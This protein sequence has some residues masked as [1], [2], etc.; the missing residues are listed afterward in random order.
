MKKGRRRAGIQGL[1]FLAAAMLFAGAAHASENV[2]DIS[3]S[4]EEYPRIDGSLA[5]VPLCEALAVKATGCTQ[6]QAEETMSDFTNTNPCYL[7]LAEGNRDILLAY[8][9]AEETK[10]QLLSYPP[11]D[12]QPIGKDALV[13]IVNKEN[14]VESVTTDQI[15]AI[16]TGDIRNWKE[17]G[18]ADMEIAAFRRPET[19]G[20]Q[21]MLRK[22]LL[23]DAQMIDEQMET[24]PSM[25]GIIDRIRDYDNSANALGYSVYYYA[26][27]MYGQEDLKFLK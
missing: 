16:F 4:Y 17:V 23:G 5:C 12:M 15:R 27:A 22:L 13:F 19:S 24:V 20:S 25:E 14:P 7:Q 2:V 11:L 3:M 26:S 1:I 6:M 9:P 8:E 21:T 10:Q 18:G